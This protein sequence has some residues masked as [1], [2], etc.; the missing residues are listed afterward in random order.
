MKIIIHGGLRETD[1]LLE[2]QKIRDALRRIVLESYEY[3]QTHNAV[4]TAIYAIT[5]LESDPLFNAGMGSEIQSD[6]R[7]RMSASICDGYNFNMSAVI[8]IENVEHQVLVAEKLMPLDDKVLAG[9]EAIEFARKEG[10]MFFSP[11][12]EKRRKEYEENMPSKRH[13]TVGCVV[14]DKDKHIAAATSTG[15]KG[16]EIAGRV[17]DSATVAGNYAN[18][19]CG[20]SCCGIGEDIVNTAVAAKIVTRVSDYMP[21]QA[22]MDKSMQE[23]KAINGE[24]AAIGISVE[25]II[26]HAYSKTQVYYASYDGN[27]LEVF[28]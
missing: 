6:G 26:C 12:T 17:P 21:I 28:D 14:F 20:V 18:R 25:G 7:I 2:L 24:A 3:L 4:K 8:N 11:E 16:A 23:L 13:A 22:A 15:G 19:Y 1:D 9:E 5:L 10:F 27:N